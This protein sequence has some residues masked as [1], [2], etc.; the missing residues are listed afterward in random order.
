M[1][2]VAHCTNA[3]AGMKAGGDGDEEMQIENASER[4]KRMSRLRF[5]CLRFIMFS[6][7]LLP[8]P[9]PPVLPTDPHQTNAPAKTSGK[10]NCGANK[11]SPTRPRACVSRWLRRST[12]PPRNQTRKRR[13][14]HAE[15]AKKG[16]AQ[17]R[18][19]R[20]RTGW[21]LGSVGSL[22]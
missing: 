11:S 6:Q 12:C 14:I 4:K 19:R 16:R 15:H 18:K 8:P 5:P 20:E 1:T 3:R 2:G 9:P 17:Q 13:Q 22:R 7:L 10:W 21:I